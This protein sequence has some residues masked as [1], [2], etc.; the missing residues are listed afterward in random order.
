LALE[1]LK[2]I[3]LL[4]LVW[5]RLRIM[6]LREK[7]MTKK[8]NQSQ[9][10]TP[11]LTPFEQEG[12]RQETQEQTLGTESRRSGTISRASDDVLVN[13]R[14]AGQLLNLPFRFVHAA[15]PAAAPL[16][17][18]ELEAMSEPFADF[19]VSM[20]WEKIGKSSYVLFVQLA[21]A[22]YVRYRAILDFKRE[23]QIAGKKT[24]TDI[25]NRE[26][27]PGENNVCQEPDKTGL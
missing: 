11:T 5:L 27:R 13:P 26:A 21:M 22:G 19:L 2:S 25:G 18:E 17:E 3:P 15:C 20:G 7:R 4:I 24:Q 10:T 23:Q 9:K 14:V 1:I 16:T 8:M 6:E 12:E